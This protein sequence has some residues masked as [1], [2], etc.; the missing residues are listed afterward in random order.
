MKIENAEKTKRSDKKGKIQSDRVFVFFGRAQKSEEMINNS[1][2]VPVRG[3]EEQ[4]MQ[5]QGVAASTHRGVKSAKI[6]DKHFRIYPT[7]PTYFTLP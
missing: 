6:E 4:R 1:I 7:Y 5:N 3:M 2:H